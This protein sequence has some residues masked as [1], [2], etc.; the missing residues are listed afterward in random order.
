MN[1]YAYNGSVKPLNVAVLQFREYLHDF[2]LQKVIL[3][4]RFTSSQMIYTGEQE[5]AKYIN[6]YVFNNTIYVPIKQYY[7]CLNWCQTIQEV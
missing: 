7:T 3:V 2:L 1:F 6:H 5:R 4:R